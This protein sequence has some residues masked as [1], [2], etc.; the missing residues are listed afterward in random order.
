MKFLQRRIFLILLFVVIV[1]ILLVFNLILEIPYGEG[2]PTPLDLTRNSIMAQN[3]TTEALGQQT[4]TA[5][6]EGIG[7]GIPEGYTISP[8]TPTPS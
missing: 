1:V 2:R 6:A 3:K 4:Q 8:N 5:S 7:Q